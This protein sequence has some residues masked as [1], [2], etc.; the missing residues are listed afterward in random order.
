MWKPW[1]FV[2]SHT[3]E[4]PANKW[5]DIIWAYD[6]G[7]RQLISRLRN[8]DMYAAHNK[9]LMRQDKLKKQERSRKMMDSASQS[10]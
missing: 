4:E 2:E 9:D 5:W 1:D 6:G 8:M 10:S 7:Q 3:R